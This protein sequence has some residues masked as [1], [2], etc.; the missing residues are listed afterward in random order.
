MKPTISALI[1]IATLAIA[2]CTRSSDIGPVAEAFVPTA[3][4]DESTTP[5]YPPLQADAKI[6]TEFDY[7]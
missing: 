1:L 3:Q 2:G 4:A 6:A 5:L 7:Y